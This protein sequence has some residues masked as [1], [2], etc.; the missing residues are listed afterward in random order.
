MKYSFLFFCLI[1]VAVSAQNNRTDKS[2]TATII[3]TKVLCKEPGKYIGWPTIT[4]TR[5]NELLVVFSGNRDAHICPYGITQMIRSN[6]DGR[7]WSAPVTINNTPLDDRDA[8]ILETKKGTLLVSWFTSLAFDTPEQYKEHP[9]W[10]RHSEKLSN[11]TRQQ[12][13]GNWTRRSTDGGKTWKE[14]VKQGVSA[15]HGPIELHNNKLLYVGTGMLNGKKV[16]GIEQSKNDGRTW[17]FIS[18]IEIPAEKSIDDFYEPHVVEVSDNKLVALFRYVAEDKSSGFLHQS[19]SYDGGKSW[20]IIHTTPM[21]GYPAHLLKLNNGWILAV[22][23][24]RKPP[25]G[26]RACISKDGGKSW[27]I[28]NEITL[29]LSET[30]DLGYPASVQLEDGSILTVYYQIDQP[31]EKTCLMATHWKL[32]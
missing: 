5:N 31:G 28:D 15:P 1:S 10:I 13:L 6:D 11:E 26:E 4:R 20:S 9:E 25:F 7:T 8:G 22:Y 14:P 24:V 17:K 18:A 30:W 3:E 2:T 19:E 27:D 21:W 12:W 23:G 29:S 16:I 32:N